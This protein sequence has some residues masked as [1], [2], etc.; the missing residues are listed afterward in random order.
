MTVRIS[1]TDWADAAGDEAVEIARAF[2]AHG[3]DAIDV[4]TG[5]VVADERPEFGRSY[6]TP[7][8]DR[9]RHEAR[10]PVIA[11]GAISSWD[12]VNSLI[13]AGRADLC[14][15]GRPPSV[16]PAL[17]AAR[18]RRAGLRRP[19]RRLATLPGGQQTAAYGAGRRAQAPAH[20]EELTGTPANCAP[21]RPAAVRAAPGTRPPNAPPASPGAAAARGVRVSDREVAPG[22]QGEEIVAVGLLGRGVR[23]PLPVVQHARVPVEERLVLL[24]DRGQVPP[25]GHRL[26]GGRETQVLAAE[27]VDVPL[28][29]PDAGGCAGS[30]RTAG[31]G[32]S[33]RRAPPCRSRARTAGSAAP[34]RFC[35]SVSGTENTASAP[36][37][38]PRAAR[39]RRP[40]GRRRRAAGGRPGTAR[41]PPRPARC[42]HGRADRVHGGSPPCLVGV[43][44]DGG[45]G[46]G[47]GRVP[48]AVGR[49]RVGVAEGRCGCGCRGVRDVRGRGRGASRSH[50]ERIALVTA[51]NGA[52][53]RS[54]EASAFAK[55][56]RPC[57]H[58]HSTRNGPPG[59]PSCAPW[60]PERL[61]PL[62]EK[63]E[64]GRVNRP[65]VAELGHLGLLDRLFTAGALDLCLM[66]ESLAHACT[67]AETA[68]ALQGLGAHPVHAHGTPAQRARWLPGRPRGRR[69]R[70]LRPDG[71]RGTDAAALA[72]SATPDQHRPLAA[73]RQQV[74]DLQRPGGRL[75][76]RLRPDSRRRRR[77]RRHRVPGA[78]RPARAG[79]DRARH[80]LPAPHRHPG[81]GRR[82]GHRR[83]RAGGAR[84]GLP[85][86]HGHPQPLPAER[87]RLR[88]RDGA[89]RP[90]RDRRPHRPPRGLR[91][92][93]Q[94]AADGRPPGGGDGPADRGGPA[95]GVRGGDGVRRGRPG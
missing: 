9:I 93:A 81:A 38:P 14:A 75:L 54:G 34:V 63:G 68:L 73:Q 8:A 31:P 49:C 7:F 64:P 69:D 92:P 80:A 65:L 87:R 1:A 57:P 17:D 2:A 55:E 13:L 50:K 45:Q 58:S 85:G 72:L 27:E 26:D 35:R 24:G 40:A 78:R 12:D 41:S 29:G 84:P 60:P 3:A 82:P 37:P 89:G 61:R 22:V 32:R 21:A 62:A 48:A 43:G 83:R 90:R 79:R 52:R 11:V 44:W 74:L 59:A 91:R 86:R 4:S 18:R 46:P 53:Y 16:R 39:W 20:P 76:H 19:G 56:D 33:T 30:P 28:R 36:S 23:P 95:D 94:R 70:R 25:A 66:R 15:L 47:R 6:Q 10:V 77:P 67:E 42:G 88:R 71:D 5:Q 51:V